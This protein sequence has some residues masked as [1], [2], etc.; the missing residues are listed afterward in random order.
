MTGHYDGEMPLVR[1]FCV[2]GHHFFGWF[3]RFHHSIFLVLCNRLV[4]V[5][6]ASVLASMHKD[7]Q[8]HRKPSSFS[9]EQLFTCCRRALRIRPR[10]IAICS[11][12]CQLGKFYLAACE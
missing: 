4:A 5:L 8:G 3:L 11:F 6:F 7:I 9:V 10:C 1:I 12:V 2:L